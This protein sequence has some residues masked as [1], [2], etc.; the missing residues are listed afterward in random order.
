M[1]NIFLKNPGKLIAEPVRYKLYINQT[2]SGTTLFKS[3]LDMKRVGMTSDFL[4]IRMKSDTL[5]LLDYKLMDYIFFRLE[6]GKDKLT[7]NPTIIE[8]YIPK[9]RSSISASIR[10]L[11]KADYIAPIKGKGL[12]RCK[13]YID[14]YKFFVGNRVKYLEAES[15]KF[16][17]QAM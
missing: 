8:R 13:Y 14:P 2:S 15:S 9:S 17:I 10:R 4:A 5:K 6:P 16:V 1:K 3:D 11:V 7:L 12:G